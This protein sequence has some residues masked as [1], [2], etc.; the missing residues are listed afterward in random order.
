M[1]DCV[2]LDAGCGKPGPAAV[3]DDDGELEF[4]GRPCT[5]AGRAGTPGGARWE[6]PLRA[7]LH[8]GNVGVRARKP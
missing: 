8:C 5:E 1:S 3:E 2:A 4:F 6:L 7:L